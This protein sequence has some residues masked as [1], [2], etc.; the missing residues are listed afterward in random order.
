MGGSGK[1]LAFLAILIGIGSIA[2]NFYTITIVIPGESTGNTGVNN[3]KQIWYDSKVT[4]WG[5]ST[6]YTDIQDLS[7][8]ITVNEGDNLYISFD[9]QFQLYSG[10][11]GGEIRLMINDVAQQGSN[12]IFFGD[13]NVL[14]HWDSLSLQYVVY[15]LTARIY[16]IQIQ[17]LCA[18][19]SG[20]IDDM[21]LFAFTFT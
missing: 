19:G 4:P 11:N 15:D 16:E 9:G 1:G 6:S 5:P 18:G 2:F 20:L 3:I 10:T 7:L 17:A 8:I 13:D 12:R 14:D 21:N